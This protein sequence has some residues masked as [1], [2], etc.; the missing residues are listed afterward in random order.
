[1][2]QIL[3]TILILIILI[4]LLWASM[5]F[6]S[7]LF[8]YLDGVKFYGINILLFSISLLILWILLLLCKLV[9]RKKIGFKFTLISIILIV[10]L[11]GSSLALTLKEFV[12]FEVVHDVSD[13]YNMTTNTQRYNLS[14][15]KKKYITFNS[16]Y[17]THYVIE[18]DN[19]LEDEFKIE[20][21]Y[22]ECYYDFYARNTSNEL[23]VSLSM[24]FRDR[25]SVYIE[26]L[27]ENTIYDEDELKRYTV[28]ILINEKDKDR[29]IVN[30]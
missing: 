19:K 27:K 5:L 11:I 14:T 2:C 8:A 13:K 16:E 7:S 17:K 23:Y 26:N 10:I 9:Y 21:K 22:Y 4:L 6:V 15:N 18:Y 3:G 30:N 1:V 12:K 25:L 20:V 29:I 24:D 28:K